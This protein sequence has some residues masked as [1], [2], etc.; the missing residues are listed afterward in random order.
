MGRYEYRA[1]DKQ[2]K[3]TIGRLRASSRDQAVAMLQSHGLTVSSLQTVAQVPFWQQNIAGRGASLRDLILFFRQT[4]SMINAGVPILDAVRAIG[5]QLNKRA[6]RTVLADISYD[7]EA[8]DSLSSAMSKHEHVFNLFMLGLVRTGEVSG[9]LSES[10]ESLADYLEQDYTFIRKVRAAFAYPIFVLAV[11][12]ILIIILFTFILPQLVTL[13]HEA[14]VTLPLPTRVL[15]GVTTFLQ[16]FWPLLTV[17]LVAGVLLARSYSRT[18]DGRYWL[19]TLM[20]RI[21]LLSTLLSKLYLA[22]LTSVLHT[23]FSSDVPALESLMLAKEAVGNRVYQRILDDTVDAVKDGASVSSVW[24]HEAYVPSMLTSMVE[25]GERSGTVD[26]S[27]A[28]ASRF[29]R[30]DV[31]TALETINVLLE[32]IL[33]IILGIGVGFVVAA[34]LLPIYNLVL[35]L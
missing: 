32:P 30:K 14:G 15:I 16:H 22:R 21:P 19:S 28:E 7:I 25:V 34:V 3:I 13:F 1:R 10:L 24:R 17:L 9:R 23:L 4:A 31:E 29:F 35:V 11:V 2:G 26:K 33:V 27:F 12:I 18:P 20:L 8:G 6:F 5:N